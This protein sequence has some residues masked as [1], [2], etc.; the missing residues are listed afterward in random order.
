MNK[1]LWQLKSYVMLQILSSIY[2]LYNI[3]DFCYCFYF[4]L[5]LMPGLV[6]IETMQVPFPRDN[7]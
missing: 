4:V 1:V 5:L 2:G 3:K 6:D 7:R